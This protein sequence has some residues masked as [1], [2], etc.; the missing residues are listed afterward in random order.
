[1]TF[2]ESA[3]EP[4]SERFFLVKM[5]ARRYLASGQLSAPGKY[6]FTIPAG[7]FIDSVIIN[8][9][10]VLTWVYSGTQIEITSALDLT[11]PS[12]VVTL[13]HNIFLTG[14]KIR[15]TAGIAGLP[16]ATWEPLIENYP[17]FNQSMR[18]IA[19]GVFSLSNTDISFICTDRWGQSLIGKPDLLGQYESLSNAPVSVWVCIDSATN[20]RK[21]FDGEVGS[22]SYRYGILSVSVLDTFQKL[23]NTASF[24]T[25]A[26][27][28]V[29]T[30]NGTMYPKPA[31]E[32]AVIPIILGKSSPI[33]VGLG[34]RQVDPFG[35]PPCPLYNIADGQ[36]AILVG[37]SGA[38]QGSSTTWIAGRYTGIDIKRLTFGSQAGSA[39]VYPLTK[40]QN[41]N[42][43]VPVP[44]S[45]NFEVQPR[46][47][48]PTNY[49]VFYR[50]S[51]IATFNGEIGDLLPASA[52]PASLQSLGARGGVVCGFG[53]NLY[54][55]YNL[56]VYAFFDDF[57]R[58]ETSI[59]AAY[60]QACTLP[61]DG[62]YPSFSCWVESGDTASYD[63]EAEEV[64][65][66]PVID[67]KAGF[68]TSYLMPT[69]I[70]AAGGY[71]IGGQ[72]VATLY[73]QL[74]PN[75][76]INLSDAR[77]K[78]RFSPG[79]SMSHA[80]ALKFIVKSAG[81]ATNDATFTQ[82]QSD[83]S[84][85][86]SVT[87]PQDQASN[88]S[89]YLDAAQSITSS[90]LGLLRV[91]QS[92]QVEY[93]LIKNPQALTTDGIR[94]KVNMLAGE[95]SATVEYQ[96]IVTSVEFE[97]PQLVNLAALSGTG[98][99]AVVDLPINKQLHRVEK[100]K[101]VQHVLESIQNRKAAIAG[102]LGNPT[103]EY[104]LSTASEDLAS[105]IGDVIEIQNTAVADT[106]E[107]AKGIITSL[108]QSGS[109]TNLKV[110][111]IRGVP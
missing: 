27:S 96:D 9:A 106:S 25:R 48:Y 21:I 102:Y 11:N 52:L 5:T 109:T 88:F 40:T 68:A 31:D 14:T 79:T 44:L 89:S 73:F 4:A 78:F 39:L 1:M 28:H 50:L 64:F 26:Q 60:N 82:A 57:S 105:S 12:N 65:G 10:T 47:Y 49:I 30:G 63:W 13:D 76:K 16:D 33:K 95:T 58:I 94:D 55:D 80:E 32:N 107:T 85:N 87:F 103:V 24:G 81:M 92:R 108:E 41:G 6:S 18:N 66:V 56:A 61:T 99:K 37:P 77:V 104:T 97:N 45:L 35:S 23:K 72:T 2:A 20:N 53:A 71:T 19:D 70:Y 90:T 7:L 101:T 100:S 43:K 59:T 46:T 93:E 74:G 17:S 42:L 67:N 51:N 62:T 86:V 3:L 15:E 83:L 22:V 29:Y 84:A 75:S 34:Y 98:P 38:N 8:G 91:N 36:N 111:E 110:N 54:G 69:N